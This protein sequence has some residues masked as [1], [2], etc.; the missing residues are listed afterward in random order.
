MIN[1]T[2]LLEL[3]AQLLGIGETNHDNVSRGAI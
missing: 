3:M 1:L 2:F